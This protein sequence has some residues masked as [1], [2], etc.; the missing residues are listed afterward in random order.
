MADRLL[1][2]TGT[3]AALPRFAASTGLADSRQQALPLI[4]QGQPFPDCARRRTRHICLSGDYPAW[5]NRAHPN[6][7]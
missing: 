6:T 1:R 3:T 2:G 5:V 4:G 7:M